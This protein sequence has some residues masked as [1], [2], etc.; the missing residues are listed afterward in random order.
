MSVISKAIISIL[1]VIYI[2]HKHY[3]NG[4]NIKKVFRTRLKL[5]DIILLFIVPLILLII[6]ILIISVIFHDDLYSD[7]T[8]NSVNY[9]DF[10]LTAIITITLGPIMEEYI[11]RK[12]LYCYL[13]TKFNKTIS[14]IMQSIIFGAVHLSYSA[15]LFH[16]ISGFIPALYYDKYKRLYPCIVFHSM[17]NFYAA[18]FLYFIM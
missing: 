14:N 16:F 10:M 11:F 3:P 18:I 17:S 7:E 2:R 4:F 9:I 15:I 5:E 12:K 6:K 13:K 1:I 8:T